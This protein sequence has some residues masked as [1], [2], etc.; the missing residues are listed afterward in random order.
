VKLT[1]VIKDI[2]IYLVLLLLFNAGYVVIEAQEADI[3]DKRDL[4]LSQIS[5][6]SGINDSLFKIHDDLVNGKLYTS[7]ADR[8]NYPFFS[9]NA[10]QTGRVYYSGTFTD[11]EIIKYDIC[12]DQ[13]VILLH[14]GEFSYPVCINRDVVKEFIIN[15]HHFM[16]LNDIPT[17]ELQNLI[18]GFYE[19]LYSGK[20]MLYVRWVKNKAINKLT[21][22]TEYPL[23]VY[24]YLKKD[25][26]YLQFKNQSSFIEA[27]NDHKN[28][29]ISY[30]KTNK[31]RFSSGRKDIII[32]VLEYY[33][34]L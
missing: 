25:G 21:F 20:T 32:K 34:S 26:K 8:I 30:M 24:Y 19:V 5:V 14:I 12:I 1:T 15:D 16:F 28:E 23:K 13:L 29:I 31:L 6:L 2:K 9:E 10:W 17:L 22:E 7:T 3:K 4:L 33:D 27:L 18:P 11:N